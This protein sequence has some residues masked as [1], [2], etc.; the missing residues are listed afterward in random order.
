[1]KWWRQLRLR[2]QQSNGL[3][4]NDLWILALC[5]QN[6]DPAGKWLG[7]WT[8]PLSWLDNEYLMRILEQGWKDGGVQHDQSVQ[9]FLALASVCVSREGTFVCKSNDC[10]FC[11]TMDK[12]YR[13]FY[14]Y[15]EYRFSLG[16]R[17]PVGR[18]TVML[19]IPDRD[20]GGI[21][22]ESVATLD[23]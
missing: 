1:M 20:E 23:V 3:Q 8:N 22:C 14:S 19:G 21:R 11:K 9:T 13:L 6:I 2:N 16:A 10:S 7:K 15:S 4:G 12:V 18:F 5:V 17:W